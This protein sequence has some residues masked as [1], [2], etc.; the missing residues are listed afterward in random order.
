MKRIDQLTEEE[1]REF[2]A[3]EERAYKEEIT[4]QELESW[5]VEHGIYPD[6]IV[7][8]ALSSHLGQTPD[9]EGRVW[10]V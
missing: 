7:F 9:E 10:I 8:N 6:P 5:M 1:A 2:M 3:Q 4:G